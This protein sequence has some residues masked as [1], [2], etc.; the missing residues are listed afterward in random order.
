MGDMELSCGVLAGISMYWSSASFNHKAIC[1]GLPGL[2]TQYECSLP[3]EPAC[4]ICHTAVL[5]EDSFEKT[6]FDTSPYDLIS[7]GMTKCCM[8]L[9]PT[10]REKVQC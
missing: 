3:R 1:A 2:G 5:S 8:S 6:V 4:K 10:W 9:P 7:C